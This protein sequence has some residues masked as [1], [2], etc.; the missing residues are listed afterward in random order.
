MKGEKDYGSTQENP[1]QI[2]ICQA[3]CGSACTIFFS[4][5]I[6]DS[7]SRGGHG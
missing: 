3:K 5:A 2:Y 7:F 1:R 6:A 4:L